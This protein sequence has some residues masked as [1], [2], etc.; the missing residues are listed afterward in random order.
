M[1]FYSLFAIAAFAIPQ[2]HNHS[3]HTQVEKVPRSTL[4]DIAFLARTLYKVADEHLFIGANEVVYDAIKTKY[5]MTS[6]AKNNLSATIKE[7]VLLQKSA[8]STFMSTD[9]AQKISSAFNAAV[10]RLPDLEFF[11]ITEKSGGGKLETLMNDP[12]PVVVHCALGIK[13]GITMMALN[14]HGFD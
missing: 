12:E 3:S 4:L 6:L 11:R 8:K 9:L 10:T 1:K 2:A 13:R 7:C 5:T 14:G